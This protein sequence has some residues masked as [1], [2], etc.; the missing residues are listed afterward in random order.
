MWRIDSVSARLKDDKIAEQIKNLFSQGYSTKDV[1]EKLE[2]T[3]D[4]SLRYFRDR[5]LKF[6]YSKP[7]LNIERDPSLGELTNSIVEDAALN[8]LPQK[9]VIPLTK[10][11]ENL[12]YRLKFGAHPLMAGHP[13]AMAVL[14]GK[15]RTR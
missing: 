5:C 14:N 4:I 3:K 2:I 13:L 7:N 8:L 11:E 1:W 15:G 9:E 10:I 12:R 6:G